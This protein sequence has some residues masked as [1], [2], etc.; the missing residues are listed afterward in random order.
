MSNL[1][2]K[3]NNKIANPDTYKLSKSF[4]GK[5]ANDDPVDK[6]KLIMTTESLYSVSGKYA[7][8]Y[9]AQQI[10]KYFNTTDITITDGTANVGS[11]TISL[12][13]MFTTVNSIELNDV[14]YNAL[15]NNISQYKI[16]N[17]NLYKGSSID[18][19]PTLQQDVI[20]IDAPWSSSGETCKRCNTINIYMDGKDLATIFNELKSFAKLI[21]FKVPSNYNFNHFIT[22][23]QLHKYNVRSYL[24]NDK[25][26]F[27]YIFASTG[28][29]RHDKSTNHK[30]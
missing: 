24:H 16:R 13:L 6:R 14:N 1:K 5:D 25:I 12:A 11:D 26:K 7:G 28:I 9:L 19:I 15:K 27:Y 23:T 22:T 17:V 18:I 8:A 3:I 20:F 21:I 4:P 2:E 29:K 10:Y 30:S